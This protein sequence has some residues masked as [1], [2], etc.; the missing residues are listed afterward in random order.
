MGQLQAVPTL[1]N[2]LIDDKQVPSLEA[3]YGRA[4]AIAE[5]YALSSSTVNKYVKEMRNDKEF[6]K[7]IVVPSPQI[8]LINIKGFESFIRS[9]E[10]KNF[11]KLGY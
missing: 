3:I 9:R 2:T 6:Q 7:Y 11:S 10:K 5:L 1:E 4:K 8:L